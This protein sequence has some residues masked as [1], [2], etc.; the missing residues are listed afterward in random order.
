[1][2]SP[3]HWE[4]GVSRR[5]CWGGWR[6]ESQLCPFNCQRRKLATFLRTRVS[7]FQ[8]LSLKC[9]VAREATYNA[10][11]IGQQI[12]LENQ[13]Y[14]RKRAWQCGGCGGNVGPAQCVWPPRPVL[15]SLQP[16]RNQVDTK[17]PW[18]WDPGKGLPRETARH[19]GEELVGQ[20]LPAPLVLGLLPHGGPCLWC[21][22]RVRWQ[23]N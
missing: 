8:A 10:P 11:K 21:I 6:L 2:H 15:P 14:F 1:M 16:G 5:A 22:C 4:G 7:R 23:I 18:G 17:Y 3:Q 19:R 9:T 13:L 12:F 20:T